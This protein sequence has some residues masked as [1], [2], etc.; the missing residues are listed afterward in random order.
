MFLNLDRTKIEVTLKELFMPAT[1]EGNLCNGVGYEV[2]AIVAGRVVSP[3][4]LIIAMEH[5]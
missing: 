3:N 2:V 4:P 5:P 1:G